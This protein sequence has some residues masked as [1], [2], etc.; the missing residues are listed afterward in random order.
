MHYHEYVLQSGAKRSTLFSIHS[1]NKYVH[2]IDLSTLL[3][4]VKSPYF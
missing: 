3:C 2:T 4:T 1:H